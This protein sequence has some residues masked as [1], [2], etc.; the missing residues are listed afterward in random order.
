MQLQSFEGIQYVERL[1]LVQI[2]KAPLLILIHGYGSNEQDLFSFASELPSKY[3]IVSLRGIFNIP[4]GGY[5]WYNID[6]MNLEKHSNFEQAHQSK[7][8]I[9]QFITQFIQEKNLS[10]QGVTLCGFSQGCI[11][12][13]ALAFDQPQL[14]RNIIALSGY[15]APE[16]LPEN[17]T[18][19]YSHLNFFISH[20][21]EDSVIPVEWARNI[22]PLL[23]QLNIKHVYNEYPAG[24]GINPQNYLDMMR[25]VHEL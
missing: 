14:V 18:Q 22:K 12:S 6:F 5:G 7:A 25:W 11:L 20:G 1:P 2:E 8:K 23:T 17:F 16:L 15:P 9:Q 3:H 24:H 19:D 21:K 13:Y 4:F 10:T